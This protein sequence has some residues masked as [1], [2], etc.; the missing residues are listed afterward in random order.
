MR[1]GG[2][3]SAVDLTVGWRSIV[4]SRTFPFVRDD[5]SV[6]EDSAV[7]VGMAGL[8]GTGKSTLARLLAKELGAA[9]LSKDEVRAALFPPP[10]L[11]YSR[12]QDDLCMEAIYRAAQY[13]LRSNPSLAVIIDGRTF[14]RAYQIRDLLALAQSV[15]QSPYVI[16][17]VCGDEV[18]RRRLEEDLKEGRHPAMNRTYELYQSLRSEAEPISMPHLILD[19]GK[20]GVEKCVRDAL[21]H[22][23]G[24]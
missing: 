17:C 4:R 15:G 7:L 19:T 10:S 23:R 18:A 3:R 8:P 16:E 13:T 9:V 22:L 12:E 5:D 2:R 20:L 6:R 24:G 1:R 11:D 21:A 14:L